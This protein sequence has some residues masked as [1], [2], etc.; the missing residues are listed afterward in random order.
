MEGTTCIPSAWLQSA[1]LIL[2]GKYSRSYY[3]TEIIRSFYCLNEIIIPN[4]ISTNADS[5]ILSLNIFL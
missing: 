3:K 2:I 5:N 4:Q 1:K